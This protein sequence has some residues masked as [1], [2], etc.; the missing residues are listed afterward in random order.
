MVALE[1]CAMEQET[2]N[3][4]LWFL[5]RNARFLSEKPYMYTY[6][7]DNG[8]CPA[9][10]E[11]E[12]H[13]GILIH[14]L[15]YRVP[16]FEE[17]GIAVLHLPGLSES[18]SFHDSN[19]VEDVLLP[20]VREAVKTFLKADIV[21]ILEYKLRKRDARFPTSDIKDYDNSQPIIGAHV[22]YTPSEVVRI[23]GYVRDNE[24]D[25]MKGK[26]IQALNVWS[27][28]KGP[29]R[30][31]PLCV[32]DASSVA[33]DDLQTADVIYPDRVAENFQVCHSEGQRW[34][35]IKDQMPDELLVFRATDTEKPTSTAVP[36][37]SFQITDHSPESPLR[38]SIEMR[39]VI[40]HNN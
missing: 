36:H 11:H 35:Y 1:S 12:P 16:P 20:N 32:C 24:A 18:S 27:P 3:A 5:K 22:D 23:L 2:E 6:A 38:E 10:V 39:V 4:T 21:H 26:R 19:H 33:E 28:L 34:Y 40:I 29:L 14:N 31:W 9:N 30:D 17:S 8:D 7:L 25:A 13:E 15:R 37:C